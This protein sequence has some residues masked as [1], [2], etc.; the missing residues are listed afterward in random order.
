MV[1]IEG[2]DRFWTRHYSSCPEHIGRQSEHVG[3]NTWDCGCLGEQE[4]GDASPGSFDLQ[5]WGTE[6]FSD[7]DDNYLRASLA[8]DS[9]SHCTDITDPKESWIPSGLWSQNW[10]TP[11][12]LETVTILH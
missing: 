12:W 1:A 7:I 6:N 9:V 8:E 11:I 4:L 3:S 5:C 10:K 2:S